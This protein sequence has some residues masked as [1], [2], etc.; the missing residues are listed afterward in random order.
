MFECYQG[1]ED[2]QAR[3]HGFYFP[4]LLYYILWT[5][6]WDSTFHMED[7]VGLYE[8]SVVAIALTLFPISTLFQP[9]KKKEEENKIHDDGP[10][11]P[12]YPDNIQTN[13]ICTVSKHRCAHVR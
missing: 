2:L 13:V 3:R 7:L 10:E 11:D 9:S 8:T 5:R 12:H 1:N 4:P 6:G